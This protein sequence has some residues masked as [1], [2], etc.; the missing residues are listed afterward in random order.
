MRADLSQSECEQGGKR[1][2][3]ADQGRGRLL[4]LH[5]RTR[6]A[7]HAAIKPNARGGCQS[8]IAGPA[9]G[10]PAGACLRRRGCASQPERLSAGGARFCGRRT[11]RCCG[12]TA[13]TGYFISGT[14]EKS[15]RGAQTHA[16]H[17]KCRWRGFAGMGRTM[18][19]S[20]LS[21]SARYSIW[22]QRREALQRR[23]PAP[24]RR[25]NHEPPPAPAHPVLS[26]CSQVRGRPR[27]PLVVCRFGTDRGNS[28]PH[29]PKQPPNHPRP[30]PTGP[31]IR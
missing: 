25:P 9:V 11:S 12:T 29:R 7:G 30:P 18:I 23:S 15:S 13:A 28:T 1:K 16:V 10:F 2:M 27:A 17:A 31:R 22:R 5:G 6:Q 20:M 14:R 19:G 21:P 8:T 24:G 4:R 26:S 3:R